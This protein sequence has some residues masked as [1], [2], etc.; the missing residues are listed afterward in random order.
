M[1]LVVTIY[2]E[3]FE[4]AL[5]AIRALALDHDM[6]E[7]RAEKFGAIDLHALRAATRKPIILTHRGMRVDVARDAIAAG[8]DFVDVEWSDD[9][10]IAIPERTVLSHH[11]YEGMRDV[12]AIFANM[13]AR[14]CAHTK[15]AATPQDFA[16]NERLLA[17][18]PTANGQRPTIIGMGERGLYARVL[19]PFRGSQLTFVAGGAVAAPAQLTLERALAIYGPTRAN[20]RAEKVFAIVGNPAGHSLSPTIHNALFREKGV[21]GAYTI[22]SIA[23]FDEITDA[24]L[25]GEPCGISITAP[26]K[27]GAF[28]FAQRIDAEIGE[29]ARACGAVNTLVNYGTHVLADNTDVDGFAAILREICG[30]DRKSVALVGAGGTA[31]AALTA[32]QR[33]QMHVM[34]F[35]RTPG[36]LGAHPL[37]ELPRFDGEVVINT[38]P[39]DIDIAIKPGMTYIEAKYGQRPTANG[40]RPDFTGIDLL[41]AQAKRQHELFMRIF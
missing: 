19:A 17:L 30:R 25:R 16:D 41:H 40:Q 6:I 31:R 29:N 14:G 24:F 36:K 23:S 9:V 34:V 13:L 12:E 27:E 21:P 7:L 5:D 4:A 3:T 15:L 8:I 28:A 32:L 35:N 1:Q 39:V 26:F 18:R 20:L 33:E 22:A 38:L 37:D 11:D 10:A 2:E